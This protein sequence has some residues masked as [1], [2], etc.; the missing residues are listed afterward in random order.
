MA[1]FFGTFDFVSIGVSQDDIIASPSWAVYKKSKGNKC[2]K[3]FVLS[4]NVMDLNN[5]SF[6]KVVVNSYF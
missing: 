3:V 6:F 4:N 2:N 5:I 1:G